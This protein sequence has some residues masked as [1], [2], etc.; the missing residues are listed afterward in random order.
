ML[1]LSDAVLDEG[2]IEVERIGI[3][4]NMRIQCYELGIR[5]GDWQLAERQLQE[6]IQNEFEDVLS[7]FTIKA[8]IFRKNMV[9]LLEKFIECE[10]WLLIVKLKRLVLKK[11]LKRALQNEGL[12][13]LHPTEEEWNAN[14]HYLRWSCLKPKGF[15]PESA[16]NRE[17]YFVVPFEHAPH[18]VSNRSVLI[19]R[20]K[21]WIREEQLPEIVSEL[22]VMNL[23]L[24]FK[25]YQKKFKV[26]PDE[27][28]DLLDSL[29]KFQI[30]EFT[31]NKRKRESLESIDS[32]E[33]LETL[34]IPPCIQKIQ[35]QF[36]NGCKFK[37][38]QTLSLFYYNLNL[39]PDLTFDYIKKKLVSFMRWQK[40]Y[41]YAFNSL[42]KPKKSYVMTNC[43]NLQNLPEG[44]CAASYGQ[45][46]S[47]LQNLLQTSEFEF[48]SPVDYYNLAAK[49]I[50]LSKQTPYPK[51][52]AKSKLNPNYVNFINKD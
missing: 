45:C 34:A 8:T 9:V 41:E 15:V 1:Y 4:Q 29:P 2:Q 13:F 31:S 16:F 38:R 40:D 35:S 39:D 51:P 12:H 27:L 42:L 43:R 37:S 25:N 36:V 5:T 10:K 26:E 46:R 22:F 3:L 20:G 49:K 28:D 18:L 52:I 48:R 23:R 6:H 21:A 44:G 14:E 30:S 47:S 19:L 32:P 11:E 33:D 17:N 24:Q 50:K 7:H